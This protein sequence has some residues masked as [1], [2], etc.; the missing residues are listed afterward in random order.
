[1]T[2]SEPQR[3]SVKRIMAAVVPVTMLTQVLSFFSSLALAHVLGATAETDAYFLALSIPM[4]TFGVLQAALRLGAIPALTRRNVSDPGSFSQVS[5][6]LF[7]AV[8]IAA[9]V[10]SV[11]TTAI[12]AFV[13][14]LA[15]SGSDGNLA[16]LTRTA[17]IELAPLGLFGALVG[18][19]S[20]IV[21]VRGSF[22]AAA[23]ILGLEPIVKTALVLTLGHVWGASTLI[24]GNLV[25]SALGVVVLWVVARRRGVNIRFVTRPHSALVK[26]ILRFSVPLLVSQSVLQVS[27]VIDRSMA[28]GINAGSV[29]E[30]E[31]GLR[32][33]LIPAGLVAAT[34]MAPLTATWAVRFEEEG[35]DALRES[36]ARALK[37]A[38]FVV[39]PLVVGGMFVTSHVVTLLYAGGAYGGS[40]LGHTADVLGMLLLGLPAQLLV[41]IL[42]TVFIVRGDSIFPMKIAI[43]NVI[44]NVVLNLALRPVMGVAGIALSTTLTFT[45]LAIVYLLS[46]H[47]RWQSFD[48][49]RLRAPL[50]RAAVSG[51]GIGTACAAVVGLTNFG[52]DRAGA[53]AALLSV[54]TAAAVVHAGVHLAGSSPA[55][56]ALAARFRS[57]SQKLHA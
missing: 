16:N 55:R 42:A 19:L 57:R 51:A 45:I 9:A 36:I 30:L 54:G 33:F 46:A 3:Q 37:A 40:A 25:G 1:V 52:G 24:V 43:A 35:P 5:S 10:A 20:A 49:D 6:E 41:V 53:V 26:E 27:P 8:A 48:F 7:T 12:A 47:R 44:L 11:L 14:P 29:T 32:L 34:L 31:L 50:A 28:A 21:A 15:V 56:V 18:V 13:L 4:I 17:V 23:A 22:T 38:A 39:P 2:Q